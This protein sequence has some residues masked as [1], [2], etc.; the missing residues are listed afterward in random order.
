[1][2]LIWLVA[3]SRGSVLQ[4]LLMRSPILGF[5][6]ILLVLLMCML[7][8]TCPRNSS[9]RQDFQGTELEF[10]W[11]IIYLTYIRLIG[12]FFLMMGRSLKKAHW[13]SFLRRVTLHPK[14]SVPSPPPD[15]TA[16]TFYA[17]VRHR[18]VCHHDNW[19]MGCLRN[20]GTKIMDWRKTLRTEEVI[21]PRFSPQ[22]VNGDTRGTPQHR[23]G[24]P[25][26]HWTAE[27]ATPMDRQ[28]DL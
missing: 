4:E 9:G 8:N 23:P 14:T 22:F 1:M 11:L 20:P 2:V 17:P 3:K 10:L 7:E 13:R 26:V 25:S 6:M 21:L 18:P 12:F 15:D 19:L 5:L 24:V 27:Q 28:A 16:N